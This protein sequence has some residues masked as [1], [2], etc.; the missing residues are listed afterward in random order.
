MATSL[1]GLPV[2]LCL[3]FW[4]S[5]RVCAS[6]RRCFLL[7]GVLLSLSIYT[8]MLVDTPFNYYASRYFI[9]VLVPAAMLLFGELIDTFGFR[10]VGIAA[11]AL[12]GLV[13]NLR[14]GRG[15]LPPSRA[16]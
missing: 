6:G 1:V 10:S 12:A 7:A 16:R 8:F 5:D 3:A 4:R 14:L 13:F 15:P 2:V 9:P 11:L